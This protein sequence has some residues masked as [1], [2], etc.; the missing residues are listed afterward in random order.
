MLFGHPSVIEAR[1]LKSLMSEFFQASGANVNKIKSQIFF[2]NTPATTQS[3]IARILG[4]TIAA[5]PSKYLGAPLMASAYKH[6]SW[7]I[8]LEKLEARLFLWTH[9]SLNMASRLV[10][11]KVVLHSMPLYLFSI[12][13]TPKWVLKEI[14]RLQRS[15]LWGSSGPTRKWALVKWDKF[16]LPKCTGGIGLRDPAHSNEAMGTKIWSVPL[17]PWASLWTAKYASNSPIEERIPMSEDS[18]GSV[19]WNSAKHHR[20]LIQQHC[21]WEIK[22][23]NIAQFWE[24][25]WQ[26]MPKLKNLLSH[27]QLPEQDMHELDMVN[28]FWTTS[29]IQGYRRWIDVNQ[30]LRHGTEQEAYNI[31][32]KEHI[33][34]D[35]L[36]SKVWDPPNWPKVST[37]LW[38]LCQNK[39]LTWDNLRKKIYHGPSRCPNC[40]QQEESI[41]HLMQSCCMARKLWEKVSFRCQKE[42]RVQG[43]ITATVR[44]WNKK[45]YQSKLLNT[46]WRLIPGLL[47][48]NIWKERN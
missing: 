47:M 10:L 43:D 22:N 31:I 45:P 18:N 5:L 28:N 11:I 23:G 12:L 16:C 27:L 13:A 9:R 19:I 21:F 37:F 14:K 7:K 24:D 33:M 26:Q 15:F 2:F 6:S 8:L 36:W 30:I 46:L 42:G 35:E 4:F 40:K 41:K 32:L 34:K 39:T 48:W 3:A 38:L 25:S 20:K 1:H 44:Q 29:S 17:T